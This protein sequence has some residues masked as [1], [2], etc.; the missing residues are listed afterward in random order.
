MPPRVSKKKL[1][2]KLKAREL[3]ELAVKLDVKAASKKTKDEPIAVPRRRLTLEELR[4]KIE[5]RKA[6]A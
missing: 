1:L 4:E 6:A 5:E 2:S 3:R